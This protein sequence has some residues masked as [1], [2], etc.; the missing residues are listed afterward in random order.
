[1]RYLKAIRA[2]CLCQPL[3]NEPEARVEFV[4][5]REGVTVDGVTFQRT[6]P[7]K[8]GAT[9]LVRSISFDTSDLLVAFNVV[10]IDTDGSAILSW[11]LLKSFPTPELKR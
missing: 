8:A 3:L 9:Y 6:V 1:M 4:R 2:L 7:M 5:F 11:K 10:R